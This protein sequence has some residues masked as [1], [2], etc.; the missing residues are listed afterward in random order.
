LLGVCGAIISRR[1]SRY[2]AK[3][4]FACAKS[5]STS[6]VLTESFR[7][8][9]QVTAGMSTSRGQSR[10]ALFHETSAATTCCSWVCDKPAM[11]RSSVDC[12]FSVE[13]EPSASVHLAVLPF[14]QAALMTCSTSAGTCKRCALTWSEVRCRRYAK[15]CRWS[16]QYCH[17]PTHSCVTVSDHYPH[18]RQLDSTQP[19]WNYVALGAS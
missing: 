3:Q 18:P 5:R 6:V 17:A 2:G 1:K 11:P 10:D 9:E 7:C 19:V 13:H 14:L 15:R 8:D 12:D 4:Y 16:H